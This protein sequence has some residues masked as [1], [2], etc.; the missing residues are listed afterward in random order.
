MSL[1]YDELNGYK[2]CTLS[3]LMDVLIDSFLPNLF[4]KYMSLN[5]RYTDG[6]KAYDSN[7]PRFMCNRPG[8]SGSLGRCCFFLLCKP[9]SIFR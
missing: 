7:L 2:N 8:P 1:K 9:V 5:I 3:D 6:H 4:E